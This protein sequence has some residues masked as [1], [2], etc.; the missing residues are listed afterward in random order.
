MY[1]KRILDERYSRA[2]YL[3]ASRQSHE[4]VVVD[5]SI[6]PN[7]TRSCHQGA[8][9]GWRYVTDRHTRADCMSGARQLATG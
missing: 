2:F 7:S 4:A 8:A 6:K 9:S 3:D 5:P 1:F